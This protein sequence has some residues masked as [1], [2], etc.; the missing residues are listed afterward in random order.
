MAS[1][2]D[3]DQKVRKEFQKYIPKSNEEMMVGVGLDE[4]ET[5]VEGIPMEGVTT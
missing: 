2:F 3:Y 4:I 1:N 5:Q